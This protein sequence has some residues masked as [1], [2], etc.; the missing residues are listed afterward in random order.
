MRRVFLPAL[1]AMAAIAGTMWAKA[2]DP[3][4]T[5]TATIV[6][7]VPADAALVVGSQQTEQ[8]G[9]ERR[10][11]TPGLVPG[12]TYSYQVTASWMTGGREVTSSRAVE[13]RPGQIV[14]VDMRRAATGGSETIP[15]PKRIETAPKKFEPVPAP[16]PQPKSVKKQPAPSPGQETGFAPL[17]NGKDLSGWKTVPEN[18]E[19]TFSVKDGVIVV[20]GNPNGY[21]YTDKSYQNYV[22]KFDW[23]YKRPAGLEDEK[24]FLGNSGLLY[25]IQ[26]PHKVWPKSI[27]VQGMN[28]DHGVLIPVSGARLANQKFDRPALEKARHPVGEWNTTEVAIKD[29][30][31]TA[32]VNGVQVSSGNYDLPGG[33]FGFQSEGAELHFKNIFIK[34]LPA[35]ATPPP[36]LP[37]QKKKQIDKKKLED[38]PKTSTA[39]G[40]GFKDLFNGKNLDGWKTFLKDE[41]ADPNKTFVVKNGEIQVSGSPFGYFYTEKSYKNYVIRYD[42]TYPKDQPEKTTMNSGLLVHIQEPH[43]VWPKSVEPQGRYKDHGKLFFPGFD[44]DAKTE[45]KFDEAAQQ[46]ALKPSYE[47]NTTEATCKADGS[48]TV[49]I[50]GTLVTTGRTELA[51]GQIGFQS[52]GAR[53]H[54][55]N[56]KIKLLD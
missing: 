4:A 6:V 9:S 14:F 25:H 44:K 39:V 26:E 53:I 33:P 20:S 23:R 3:P 19:K 34:T 2:D 49:K 43:K 42:W 41:G 17:F 40:D 36:P 30:S 13:F 7:R 12:Y 1:C 29:G 45:Q 31:V 54:F 48:I 32:K 22:L 27:E 10:F 38:L 51:Q 24:K 18:A 50:N 15:L 46:K 5:M 47:R 52:E 55:R 21:F 56:I 35:S 8:R 28:R 11:V 37:E 16:I